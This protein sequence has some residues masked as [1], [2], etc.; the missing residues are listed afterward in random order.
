MVTFVGGIGVLFLFAHAVFG[1]RFD[2]LDRISHL[3]KVEVVSA[4]PA[5]SIGDPVLAVDGTRVG[6][7]SGLSRDLRGRVERIRVTEAAELSSGQ[8]ILI[9]RDRYFRL[10]DGVVQLRLSI[11]EFNAMPQ[12]MTE[13][14][15]AGSGGPF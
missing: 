12:A 8:R 10:G 2:W 13:D 14:R 6:S 1:Q 4:K 15:A 9:I 7:V 3:L 11:A 5:L